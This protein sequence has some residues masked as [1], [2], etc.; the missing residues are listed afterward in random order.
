MSELDGSFGTIPGEFCYS[1]GGGASTALFGL[2]TPSRTSSRAPPRTVSNISMS[3]HSFSDDMIPFTRAEGYIIRH[4]LHS[5]PVISFS[6]LADA[7]C[8]FGSLFERVFRGQDD[9]VVDSDSDGLYRATVVTITAALFSVAALSVMCV[10]MFRVYYQKLADV[11]IQEPVRK[12]PRATVIGRSSIKPPSSPSA[13]YARTLS[14]LSFTSVNLQ[15]QTRVS[16]TFIA[17]FT[18]SLTYVSAM[19]LLTGGTHGLMGY[20]WLLILSP[21]STTVLFRD[22]SASERVWRGIVFSICTMILPAVSAGVSILTSRVKD[23]GLALPYWLLLLHI[24]WGLLPHLHGIVNSTYRYLKQAQPTTRPRVSFEDENERSQSRLLSV[25]RSTVARSPVRSPT[26]SV[27]IFEPP[28]QPDSLEPIALPA[29][30]TSSLSNSPAP[31][32]KQQRQAAMRLVINSQLSSSSDPD[33]SDSNS[34]NNTNNPG[35]PRGLTLL[36]QRKGWKATAG[37]KAFRLAYKR[38]AQ[39]GSGAFGTVYIALNEL[40]GELMAV[41]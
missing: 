7:L 19:L 31:N 27:V 15:T 34:S 30:S 38:G 41:K 18:V 17:V 3:S 11:F 14:S 9:Q 36:E 21:Q 32:K 28:T 2:A 37:D 1:T 24:M 6:L 23:N 12:R 16:G 35:S 25:R 26:S 4:L 39:I 10:A 22:N 5:L 13:A 8:V 20:L 33:T 40:T 29:L